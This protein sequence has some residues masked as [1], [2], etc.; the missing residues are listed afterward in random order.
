M[1]ISLKTLK[2]TDKKNKNG[3]KSRQELS[4]SALRGLNKNKLSVCINF[5]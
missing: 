5:D 1:N 2:D 3:R 4:I